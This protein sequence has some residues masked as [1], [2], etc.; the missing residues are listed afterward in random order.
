MITG[1]S[2]LGSGHCQ[3]LQSGTQPFRMKRILTK[4]AEYRKSKPSTFFQHPL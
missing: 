1:T 2:S 3:A 4:K